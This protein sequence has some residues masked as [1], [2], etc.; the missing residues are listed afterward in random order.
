MLRVPK[1][2]MSRGPPAW[3]ATSSCARV[4]PPL[5]ADARDGAATHGEVGK[6][7]SAHA[8]AASV[9][10]RHRRAPRHRAALG[11]KLPVV[12]AAV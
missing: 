3:I 8:A 1:K 2:P 7:G 9:P 11:G 4:R 5:L 10:L 6:V 12:R